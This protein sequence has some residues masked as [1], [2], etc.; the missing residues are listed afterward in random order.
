[1]LAIKGVGEA[2]FNKYG[3][4]FLQIIK[5]Y[6]EEK[7]ISGPVK[8]KREKRKN[9]SHIIT[10]NFYKDGKSL[11]EI[12][13]ERSIKIQT[14]QTHL[15][16][17]FREGMEVDLDEFIPAEY[18]ELILT[19]IKKTGG[20]RLRPIKDLLPDHIDYMAI[21]AVREKYKDNLKI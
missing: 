1:M 18:E 14:L 2:K 5:D 15:M 6:T 9:S 4:R 11:K 16:K 17:C 7:G 10:F 3:E 21:K 8:A 13:E 20:E 12:S 19:V